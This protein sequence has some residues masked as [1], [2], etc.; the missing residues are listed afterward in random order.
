MKLS[1][2]AAV[3]LPLVLAPAL[4]LAGGSGKTPPGHRDG[5]SLG[6]VTSTAIANGFPQG[7]HASSFPTPRAGIANVIDQGNLS[8][9]LDV[10]APAN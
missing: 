1:L 10:I 4:A 6:Q 5:G 8:A 2:T 7:K 9:T 3:V